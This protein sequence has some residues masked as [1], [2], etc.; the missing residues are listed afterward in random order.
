MHIL[1]TVCGRAGSK[2]VKSKNIRDFLGKP[3]VMH[4]IAAIALFTNK[5][6]QYCCSVAV[7]TDS[8]EM[9]KILQNQSIYEKEVLFVPR[10]PELAGDTIA[11]GAVIM[12]TLEN[13]EAQVNVKYDMVVD[14][15]I[16]SP[17]R[18]V[19]D[20][21]NLIAKKLESD[22]D[23]V[24][25]VVESRRN[26]Y[27]NMVQE[28]NGTYKPIIETAFTARQQTPIVYDMNASMYAYSPEFLKSGKRMFDGRCGIIKMQDTGVLD[29]DHEQDFELMEV[30]AKWFIENDKEFAEVLAMKN[31]RL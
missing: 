12:N 16:T 25:S 5:N 22:F 23:T 27:F 7:N 8:I 31:K 26:P 10:L 20:I 15:D 17:L 19:R 21:E 13:V 29:I 4:T 14:L 2:G 30:L 11:K 3:L 9:V 28:R 18:T 1:F 6:P 24:F